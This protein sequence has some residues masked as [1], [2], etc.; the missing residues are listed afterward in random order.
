MRLLGDEPIRVV[1]VD[2][3]QMFAESLVRILGD[4]PD[5]DVVG[6]AQSAAAGVELAREHR[7]AV[8][9]IDYGLPDADGVQA[10][11]MIRAALGADADPEDA[12]QFVMLTG[13]AEGALLA[14]AIEAGCAGFI[15]KDNASQELV[16]AVRAAGHGESVISPAMLAKLLPRLR[17]EPAH[18]GRDPRDLTAREREVL[19]LLADGL[20]TEAIER[21]LFVSRHTVRNHVQ[22]V[23][24]KLGAHSRLEAV[25]IGVRRG[26]IDAPVRDAEMR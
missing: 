1:I 24:A 2:D 17:E 5:I 11:T 22:R 7:P 15:T 8:V 9:V 13:T 4:E 16:H 25:T 18:T 14:M 10:V 19:A 6:T 3:Q 23:M 12:V 21:E 20:S 26:L